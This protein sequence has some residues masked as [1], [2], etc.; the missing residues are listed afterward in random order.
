[1]LYRIKIYWIIIEQTYRKTL[2]RNTKSMSFN[3]TTVA[4]NNLRN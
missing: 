4:S 2:K 3:S 1:M